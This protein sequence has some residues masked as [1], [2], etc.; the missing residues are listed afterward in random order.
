MTDTSLAFAVRDE[1]RV[2]TVALVTRRYTWGTMTKLHVHTVLASALSER[3]HNRRALGTSLCRI[4]CPEA[5]GETW[6]SWQPPSVTPRG[7]GPCPPSWRLSLSAKSFRSGKGQR[8]QE[9]VAGEPRAGVGR[10]AKAGPVL[11]AV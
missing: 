6:E 11:A 5:T 2:L 7:L 8:G 3:R 4:S 10:M 9:Q 1:S